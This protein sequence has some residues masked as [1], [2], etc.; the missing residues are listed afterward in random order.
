M[1]LANIGLASGLA[2]LRLISY[3]IRYATTLLSTNEEPWAARRPLMASQVNFE[4]TNCP[5]ALICMQ[6]V[7]NEQLVDLQSDLGSNWNHVGVGRN[8]GAQNGEYSPIIYQA[9]TWQL[10]RNKTYWLSQ[11]PHVFKH[12]T[13][14]VPLVFMCTHFDH[15]GTVARNESA[16]LI[17]KIS[18]EWMVQGSNSTKPAPVFL[19]GDLNLEPTEEGYQTL[20][21]PGA[22]QDI[23][24]LVPKTHWYGNAKT[25]T[26]FTTSTLDDIRID[27]LFVRNPLGTQFSTYGVLTNKFEDRVYI[28]DHRPVVVDAEMLA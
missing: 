6:E 23:K 1:L 21:T 18:D 22:F 5:E 17:I 7:L 14:G 9:D 20:T 28:S 27:Y 3:N 25:S 12:R 10:D 13:T 24:D 11:T 26:S 2:D 8:D 16:K 4:T 19:G 15:I